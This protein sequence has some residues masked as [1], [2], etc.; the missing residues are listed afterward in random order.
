MSKGI[1]EEAK[2][3]GLTDQVKVRLGGEV[4]AVFWSVWLEGNQGTF[5]GDGKSGGG[6]GVSSAAAFRLEEVEGKR[7]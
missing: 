7:G 3:R 5:E 2:W 4:E 1:P 6:G